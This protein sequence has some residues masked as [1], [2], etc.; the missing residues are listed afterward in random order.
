MAK[1][2]YLKDVE[3][4]SFQAL[5]FIEKQF[6]VIPRDAKAMF[7]KYRPVKVQNFSQIFAC[8]TK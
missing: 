7:L 8:K 1:E 4:L 6:G 3:F 5:R 2:Y